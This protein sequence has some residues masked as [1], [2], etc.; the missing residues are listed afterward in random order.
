MAEADVTLESEPGTSR[1]EAFSDGVFAIAITLLVL[2]LKVP[3][4]SA[5]GVG[6]LRLLEEQWPTYLAFA[7]S[8]ATILIM[9]VNHHAI[10]RTMI[11]ADH[12]IFLLNGLLLFCISVVP[13]P[14]AL[15]AKYAELPERTI[16]AAVYSGMFTI[17]AIVFNLLWHYALR[18]PT[19]L[20]KD[21]DHVFVGT[22]T[23]QYRLGPPAYVVAFVLAFVNVTVS[24]AICVAL[25][26]LFALPVRRQRERTG[27]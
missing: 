16:A 6:L 23:Q 24:V 11:R 7:T 9:W 5:D 14:T 3:S 10:F 15:L 22:L 19:L 13:F 1:L 17:I 26:V 20:K 8:F 12:G 2:D 27:G 25:A 4:A 18:H 21:L